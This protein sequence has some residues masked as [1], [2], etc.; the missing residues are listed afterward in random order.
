MNSHF[1]IF[2]LLT[3]ETGQ[4]ENTKIG[5][6]AKGK[7]FLGRTNSF[8]WGTSLLKYWFRSMNSN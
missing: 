8:L 7:C 4:D 6:L 3:S 5:D 2:S 1:E